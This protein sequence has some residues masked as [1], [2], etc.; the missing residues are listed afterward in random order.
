[1]Q[2]INR[3]DKATTKQLLIV[4]FIIALL[5]VG[6]QNRYLIQAKIETK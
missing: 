2:L 4:A 6:W 1:M 3:I 5:I